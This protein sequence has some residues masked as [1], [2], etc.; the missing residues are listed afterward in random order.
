MPKTLL[1]VRHA[2]SSWDD[3][4]LADHARPLNKRGKRDAAAMAQRVAER[5]ERPE[6]V[7]TSP[8]LRA[9]RTAEAVAAALGFEPES[10]VVD[11]RVYDATEAD[12]LEVIRSL[13]DRHARVLLVGHHPGITDTVN[14]LTNAK[15]EKLPTC[16]VAEVRVNVR[17]WAE[18]HE[19]GAALIELDA[20]KNH[21]L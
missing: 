17:S 18:S 7:V 12:L 14:L 8:A 6:L 9:R 20:P 15:I 1:L 11:A 16:G 21:A 10:L 3:P 19:G 2:K 5:S 4:D 13:D